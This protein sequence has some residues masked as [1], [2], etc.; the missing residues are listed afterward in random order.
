MYSEKIYH[1]I[2]RIGRSG[3]SFMDADN[4]YVEDETYVT[5][6]RLIVYDGNEKQKSLFD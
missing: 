1:L 5:K 6:T 3:D 2:T 4:Q